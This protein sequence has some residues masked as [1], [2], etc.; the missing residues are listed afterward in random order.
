[1][2]EITFAS[3]INDALHIA[4]QS[5]ESVICYGLGVTDP[6][7]IFGTTAGLEEQFGSSRVFDTPTSEN[8]MTGIGVGAAIGGLK[9]VMVHQR[10]DFFSK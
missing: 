3:A 1:M 4:M 9:P 8:A 6:K 5:D 2:A 7:A 10:L